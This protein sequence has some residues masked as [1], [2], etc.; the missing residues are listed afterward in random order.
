MGN[1]AAQG[2]S[3]VSPGTIKTAQSAAKVVKDKIPAFNVPKAKSSAPKENRKDSASAR[4]T[5]AKAAPKQHAKSRA[6]KKR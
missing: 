5:S 1:R 3:L 6:A 2:K 4:P